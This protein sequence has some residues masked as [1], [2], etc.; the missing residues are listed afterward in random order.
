MSALQEKRMVV[1]AQRKAR[2][3]SE[4][5]VGVRNVRRYFPRNLAA[6]ELRMGDLQIECGLTPDFWRGQPDISD[7]RLCAWLETKHMHKSQSR[8]QVPLSLIPEGAN[9][10]RLESFLSLRRGRIPALGS[11]D[12]GAR[13]N[14]IGTTSD[15]QPSDS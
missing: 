1:R 15:R 11:P 14:L 3:L 4:L 5:H 6:V 8:S 13:I 7:P 2:G 12:C 10:F 9:A